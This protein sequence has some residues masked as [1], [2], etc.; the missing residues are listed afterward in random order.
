MKASDA[1]Q[2]AAAVV[3]GVVAHRVLGRKRRSDY[4][5]ETRRRIRAIEDT[6]G[7]PSRDEADAGITREIKFVDI[8]DLS[9]GALRSQAT[10]YIRELTFIPEGLGSSSRL[11]RKVLIKYCCV[12][13]VFTMFF[14]DS[15]ST[16]WRV[17]IVVDTQNNNTSTLNLDTMLAGPALNAFIDLDQGH[18]YQVLYDTSFSQNTMAINVPGSPE[19]IFGARNRKTIHFRKNLML[20]MVFSDASGG[21]GAHSTNSI[22]L[23]VWGSDYNGATNR[24]VSVTSR[25]RFSDG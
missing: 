16:Q 6:Y 10:A 15:T 3:G 1:Q 2:Y 11:G 23:V 22:W 24:N 17:L 14:S 7:E 13:L 19:I 25:V 21:A 8:V 9:G 12:K 5:G 20:P 18:R 4:S